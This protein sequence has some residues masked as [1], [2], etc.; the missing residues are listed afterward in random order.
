MFPDDQLSKF[1]LDRHCETLTQLLA[2]EKSLNA[3]FYKMEKAVKSVIL[4]AAAGEPLLL[5]GTP[6]TAKSLLIR[7]FCNLLGMEL[8]RK[9]GDELNE[10][11]F[12]Y[13]LT[14]FTEPGELFG[15]LDVSRLQQ[16][17][18][19]QRVEEGMMQKARVVY[20][21]EV[22][23]ASSAVLNSILSVL[24]EGYL[25]SYGGVIDM[26]MICLFGATNTFK[27]TQ[28]L[29]AFSDRFVMRCWLDN[30]SSTELG[31]L[32]ES[33]WLE[34]FGANTPPRYPKLL[35]DLKTFREDI[36]NATKAKTLK[37]DPNHKLIG[38][39][40][41]IVEDLRRNGFSEMSNRRL[42]KMSRIM[43]IHAL[44]RAVKEGHR[45]P[46]MGYAELELIRDYFVDQQNDQLTY[47]FETMR[48][49]WQ[50]ENPTG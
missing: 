25:H 6:G 2:I 1:L 22:F 47:F 20:L 21:D 29:K 37:P 38:G 3:R 13:L 30:V 32:L 44:L 50:H 18:K 41:V 42:V 33:G 5:V 4:A 17:G 26:K 34:T 7:E 15:H 39:L 48:G 9:K 40:S 16:G 24:N 31:P 19:Y 23:N 36:G 10:D 28:E 8:K 35:N 14:S 27:N 49:H 43:L 12:E 11:Y 46:T 45:A